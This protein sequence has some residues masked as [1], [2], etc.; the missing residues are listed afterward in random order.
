[1]V[2]CIPYFSHE[3]MVQIRNQYGLLLYRGLP[4]NST[5]MDWAKAYLRVCHLIDM[6]QEILRYVGYSATRSALPNEPFG[7]FTDEEWKQ[8]RRDRYVRDWLRSPWKS[9]RFL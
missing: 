9:N 4:I 7:L 2:S 6:R 3:E 1:M 8:H 5:M